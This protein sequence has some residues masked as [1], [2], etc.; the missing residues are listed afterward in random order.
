MWQLPAGPIAAFLEDQVLATWHSDAAEVFEDWA[1]LRCLIMQWVETTA[2]HVVQD[3]AEAEFSS[4]RG[5][6][7]G[8]KLS[9]SLWVCVSVYLLHLIEQEMGQTW[10]N[11]HLVGFADETHLRWDILNAPQLHQALGQAH[12]VLQILEQAGLKLSPEKTARLLRLEGV[13]A[14]NIKRKII[15]KT[16]DGRRLKLGL[17]YVLPLKQEHVYLGACVTYWDFEHK[18]MKHRVHA[19]KVAFQRVR[20]FLTAEKAATLQKRLRL[21]KAIIIPT[22]MYSITASGVL[23]KGFE[24]LRVML[25]KQARAIARSPRY[26]MGGESGDE[27]ITESDATIWQKVGIGS[28]LRPQSLLQLLEGAQGQATQRRKKTNTCA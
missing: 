22:V 8:C 27:A 4:C 20:K 25:T 21:W 7:Q 13:Q 11:E 24:M 15:E 23:P 1:E 28:V 17:D 2:F 18:N 16:K 9:P 6:R 12:R 14:A 26:R 19:G 3:A 5:N 10:C